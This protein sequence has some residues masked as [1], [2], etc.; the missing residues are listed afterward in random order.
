[1]KYLVR[2][3]V[4]LVVLEL[5][6][7]IAGF[8]SNGS[9]AI[10]PFTEFNAPPIYYD[11]DALY[12]V[13]RPK[14]TEQMVNYPWGGVVYKMNAQG[15]RDD[16]FTEKGIL[17]TGNSFVEGFGVK[18]EDRF[19]EVLEKQLNIPINN[20]GS[21][22]V[23][24]AI[25]SA[26]LIKDQ[27]KAQGKQYYKSVIVLTPGE[28]VNIDTRSPENDKH[29][30]YPYRKGNEIAFHKAKHASFSGS[31]ST[32]AKIKRLFKSTLVSKIFSTFKY[33]GTAKVKTKEVDFDKNELD[34]YIEQIIKE[35]YD[36]EIAI[37]VINNL[38]RIKV[39][40]I[41]SYSYNTSKVSIDVIDF[42]DDLN[43]YFVSNG[44]L[45]SK[46]NKVLA[47]MFYKVL[48]EK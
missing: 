19:S 29:R 16:E 18:R 24:T 6:N 30:N 17:L 38:G 42:P 9:D 46:G 43:N 48:K 26:V 5:C 20:A 47:D 10:L 23:W 3:I 4:S 33:Y 35:D 1:M 7:L 39:N 41:H 45:N 11:V 37:V 36:Q 2:I 22:G 8:V 15:F 40:G 14:S 32:T 25:Q 31:L 13:T 12:G 27:L 44:H 28:V 21:G 34:W